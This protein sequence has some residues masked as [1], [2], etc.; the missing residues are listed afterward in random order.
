MLLYTL[1]VNQRKWNML[2]ILTCWWIECVWLEDIISANTVEKPWVTQVTVCYYTIIFWTISTYLVYCSGYLIYITFKGVI[3]TQNTIPTLGLIQSYTFVF[4]TFIFGS[5]IL[6]ERLLFHMPLLFYANA[7]I[8]FKLWL[9]PRNL[10][11]PYLLPWE[12]EISHFT[13]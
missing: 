9:Y 4:N 6:I 2:I 12:T 5:N 10:S 13:M 11:S 7:Y 3:C 1:D 8:N